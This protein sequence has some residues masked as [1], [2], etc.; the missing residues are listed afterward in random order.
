MEFPDV[1]NSYQSAD[2]SGNGNT[3]EIVGANWIQGQAGNALE[4]DGVNDKVLFRTGPSLE[5]KTNFTVSAMIRPSA[6][7]KGV[8]IQ[9]PNGGFN[10]EYVLKMKADGRV[11]FWMF[12]N[13]QSR[14][15]IT[16][17]PSINDGP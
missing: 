8:I 13:Y 14:F 6:T 7:S 15:N 9:Q 12:G 4:F 10:G 5:G 11:N 3:G 1:S 16:S 17:A 2:G